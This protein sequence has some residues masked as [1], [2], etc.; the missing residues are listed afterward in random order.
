VHWDKKA[1]KYC[2]AIRIKGRKKVIGHFLTL[3]DASDAY[4]AIAM[5]IHGEFFNR[6]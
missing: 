6:T 4:Q 1:G 3:K 2:A 5:I